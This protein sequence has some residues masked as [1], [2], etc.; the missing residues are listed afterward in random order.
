M[1]MILELYTRTEVGWENAPY[2]KMDLEKERKMSIK[3]MTGFGRGESS[4]ENYKFTVEIKSVNQ[5]FLDCNIRMSRRFGTFEAAIRNLLKPYIKRGKVDMSINFEDLTNQNSFLRYNEETAAAYMKYFQQMA[6]QFS[7]E[8]DVQVSV[9]ARCPEVLVMEREQADE[10][11]IW[12]LMTQAIKAAAEQLVESRIQ[13]GENLKKD[14]LL[15]LDTLQELVEGVEERSP[16]VL[17]A[18]RER[19][20]Q[21][22]QEVLED[23]MID[24]NRLMTELAIY[25]D[26]IC[27]DEETVR[28]KSH[29]LN[30]RKALDE[31]DGIGRK[32]DF[33]TQ[34]MNREANTIL[35]KANDMEI[36]NLAIEL[37]TEIEKIREQIQNIE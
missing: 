23:R 18:Y 34:E 26:K 17:V 4:D 12:A 10:E 8:N 11:E 5:R 14:L 28:L 27:V 20:T 13:E 36:S 37:K 33:V 30:M 19:L 9:L 6:E 31:G 7:I 32:L 25:A 35:S 15:K 3:S 2:R 22:I 21:K 29:M 1:I 16:E 24:E